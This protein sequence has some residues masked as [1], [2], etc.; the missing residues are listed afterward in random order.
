MHIYATNIKI[1]PKDSPFNWL[2]HGDYKRWS[3]RLLDAR[4]WKTLE[5]GMLPEGIRVAAQIG[6][7]EIVKFIDMDLP[8]PMGRIHAELRSAI[9]SIHRY[10]AVEIE[11]T[12]QVILKDVYEGTHDACLDPFW[13]V[14]AEAEE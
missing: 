6:S 5:G 4:D 13:T 3:N 14:E 8:I 7:D 2:T 12:Q 9:E 1:T 11:A 10:A